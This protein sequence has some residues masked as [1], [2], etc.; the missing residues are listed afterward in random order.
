MKKSFIILYASI[1]AVACN[2]QIDEI[3]PLTKIDQEGELSSV[4]GIVEATNGNYLL[5]RDNNIRDMAYEQAWSNISETRGNNVTLRSFGPID[6]IS[7]A[8]FF[9]NSTGSSLGYS[10]A[11]FRA[12]YQLIVSVNTALEGIEKMQQSGW[13]NLSEEDKNK[14]LYAKGEKYVPAGFSLFPPGEGIW[15]TILSEQWQ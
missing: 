5:L 13:Q 14:I 8:F 4:A 1:M 7:D 6:R 11:F 2:K 15:Q 9:R 12:S 10:S 3:R